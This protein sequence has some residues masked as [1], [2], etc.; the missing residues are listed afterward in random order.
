M[1]HPDYE[2]AVADESLPKSEEWLRLVAQGAQMG[3]W[4]WNEVTNELFWDTKT[5]EM[6]GV[7]LVGEVTVDYILW[8]VAPRR[9]S[10]C[11]GGLAL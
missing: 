11:Q 1:T 3:L 4:N 5:R 10:T 2:R 7:N 8:G 6:F 9:S